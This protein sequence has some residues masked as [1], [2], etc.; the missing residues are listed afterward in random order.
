MKK[1]SCS[2]DLKIAILLKVKKGVKF[3]SDAKLPRTLCGVV[4]VS[5]SVWEG[6]LI[7]ME[8]WRMV[9]KR[10]LK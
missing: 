3:I 4:I 6:I 9:V 8:G 2:V 5:V 7:V 1:R 10:N